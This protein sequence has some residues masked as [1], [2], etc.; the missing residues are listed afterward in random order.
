MLHGYGGHILRVD[1][2]TGRIKR[3]K[4]DPEYAR[5]AIGGRGFNS[6][7]LFDE[8]DR[9]VDPLSPENMLLI[10]VGPL[11]GSLLSSSAYMTISG[12][13]PLTG[14]LG[15]S[16]AGGFFG[17]ELKAAGYDQVIITGKAEKPS[18]LFIAD[19]TVEI[20]SA[21][22]LWGQDIWETT[23][24]L[25][26]EVGDN[27]AQIAAIGPGGENLV[28][29][30]TVACNNSRVCG[31]YRHGVPF[32]SKVAQGCCCSGQGHGEPGRSPGLYGTLPRT[33]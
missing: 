29:F 30:A 5:K 22:H 12:K 26:K 14:I 6:R 32:R 25:R 15:D 7:R 20:R 18:Y 19:D 21:E 33:R 28:K 16:A 17:P 8:L 24:S 1:L 3:E 27:A 11:T 13:S 9:G 2:T 10:G 23:R 31:P 4:T